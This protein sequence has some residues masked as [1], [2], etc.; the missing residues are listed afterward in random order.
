MCPACTKL[1]G[2]SAEVRPHDGLRLGHVEMGD[3]GDAEEWHCT[4]CGVRLFRFSRGSVLSSANL[5]VW[6]QY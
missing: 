5:G 3:K 4:D 1:V 6:E 2:T